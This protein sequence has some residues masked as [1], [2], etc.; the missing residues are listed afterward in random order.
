MNI[1]KLSNDII[2]NGI[3]EIWPLEEKDFSP[4]IANNL[5]DIE[6]IIGKH[7]Q[8]YELEKPCGRYESDIVCTTDDGET[9]IIENKIGVFDHDHFGKALTYMSYFHANTIVWICDKYYEEHIKAINQLNDMSSNEYTFYALELKLYQ[10]DN[11]NIKYNYNIVAEP[12][13]VTKRINEKNS[14]NKSMNKTSLTNNEFYDILINKLQNENI[15]FVQGGNGKS[16]GWS[17]IKYK[18]NKRLSFMMN[19]IQKEKAIQCSFERGNDEIYDNIISI[20]QNKY[21]EYEFEKAKG[22]KDKSLLKL[23]CK[24]KIYWNASPIE[25]LNNIFTLFLNIYNALIESIESI[26]Q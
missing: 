24:N 15:K 23:F 8:A 6:E 25:Q 16:Y 18:N 2:T 20:I 19:I 10:Y 22:V 11:N 21:P 4:W 7:I 9:I 3:K 13:Y 12:D 1:T 17:N 26:E 14:A 5:Q